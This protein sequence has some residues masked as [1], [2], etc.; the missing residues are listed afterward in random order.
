MHLCKVPNK[1]RLDIPEECKHEVNGMSSGKPNFVVNILLSL[2][3]FEGHVSVL[4]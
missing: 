4:L 2:V 3:A 1:Y